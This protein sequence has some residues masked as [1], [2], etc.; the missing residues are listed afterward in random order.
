MA[1][2]VLLLGLVFGAILIG[3]AREVR[4]PD[5]R[6]LTRAQ[7]GARLRRAHL[8]L[9]FRSRY[10]TKRA[11]TAVEQSPAPGD[12]VSE[13][14][15]VIAVLSAGPPPV[16]VPRTVGFS[17]GDARSSLGQLGLRATVHNV[18]APGVTAGTVTGQTPSAGVKLRPGATV[19]LSV[20]ETPRWRTTYTFTN[21]IGRASAP[22]RIR[23]TRWRIVY[24]MSYDGVCTFIFFCSGPTAH[25]TSADGATA[26]GTF[27]LNAGSDQLHSFDSGP[28]VYQ[29]TMTPGDDSANWS[30][31]V[32]DYY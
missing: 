29:I 26:L 4:V 22:F 12:R 19:S 20:A 30:V 32:E 17:S 10:S 15:R 14:S 28:G 7:I 5:V 31:Q 8:R 2:G 25:V 11:N 18:P 21:R 13:G 9:G 1:A 3:S 6:G 23:G 24:R 16:A 27:S